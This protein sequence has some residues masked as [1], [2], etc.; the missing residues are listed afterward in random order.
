MLI[1]SSITHSVLLAFPTSVL[2]TINTTLLAVDISANFLS[3][4]PP[5]LEFCVCLEELNMS[6]N[7]LWALPHLITQLSPLCILIVDLTG[8]TTL[9]ASLSMLD[10]LHILSIRRNKMYSLPSW[11]CLLTALQTLLVNSNPF[12]GP[13]KALMELCSQY[14]T[15]ASSSN[16]LVD[17]RPL[18]QRFTTIRSQSP[19]CRH[20]D[21]NLLDYHSP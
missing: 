9:S 7:P 1:G 6:S 10:K 14:V 2:P 19:F 5:A 4:L 21:Q 20:G 15:S 13:W 16:L 12:H 18:P 3:A 8:L 17:S 11:L